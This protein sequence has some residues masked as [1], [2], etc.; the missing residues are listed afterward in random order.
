M[1]A[2][3]NKCLCKAGVIQRDHGDEFR[4]SIPES[5][6]ANGNYIC[7]HGQSNKKLRRAILDTIDVLEK[8]RKAFKSKQLETLRKKLIA[9]LAEQ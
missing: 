7:S 5:P 1:C 9:L 4:C 8:T 2:D 6:S 3:K